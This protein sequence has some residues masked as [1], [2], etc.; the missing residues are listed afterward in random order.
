MRNEIYVGNKRLLSFMCLKS[1][2]QTLRCSD[3]VL[4][5]Q[6]IQMAVYFQNTRYTLC[7]SRLMTSKFDSSDASRAAT[8]ADNALKYAS[9]FSVLCMHAISVLRPWENV[10][11]TPIKY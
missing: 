10:A 1:S 11:S 5:Q 4:L 3:S 8:A 9:T 7:L 6:N 2:D